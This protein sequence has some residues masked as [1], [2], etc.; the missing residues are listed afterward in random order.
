LKSNLG[1][2]IYGENMLGEMGRK[3]SQCKFSLKIKGFKFP[4][5]GAHKQGH[6]GSCREGGGLIGEIF[7][8]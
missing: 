5:R 3:I 8:L 7:F 2:F 6:T 1:D 4:M